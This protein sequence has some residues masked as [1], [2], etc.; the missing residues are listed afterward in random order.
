VE[1]PISKKENVLEIKVG[2]DY[3]IKTI[4]YKGS[5]T[6]YFKELISKWDD[7]H[8][9]AF[10]SGI[11][12]A[13]KIGDKKFLKEKL[14]DKYTSMYDKKGKWKLSKLLLSNIMKWDGSSYGLIN[15]VIYETNNKLPRTEQVV[16]F[17]DNDKLMVKFQNNKYEFLSFK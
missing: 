16:K 12:A 4:V 1:I 5:E 9:I 8:A 6:N 2:N 7:K 15:E 14:G 10:S 11:L 13:I 17:N 3:I